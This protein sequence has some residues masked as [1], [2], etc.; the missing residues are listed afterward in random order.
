VL[1]SETKYNEYE[2]EAELFMNSSAIAQRFCLHATI[3]SGNNANVLHYIENNQQCKA[4][5]L[6]LMLVQSTQLLQRHDPYHLV[7]GKYT[8][9]QSVYNAVLRVKNEATKMFQEQSGNNTI[10][11]WEN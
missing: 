4:G 8:D 7:S 10:L 9:R 5:D 11:K 1:S 2:I 6:I 3:G